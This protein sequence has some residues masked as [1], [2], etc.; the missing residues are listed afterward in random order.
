MWFFESV[1]Y[2]FS[3]YKVCVMGDLN[4]E[5]NASDS[6]FIAFSEFGNKFK[7]VTCDDLVCNVNFTYN[8]ITLGHR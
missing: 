8:H 5:C 3:D 1:C 4:F 7:L 6:G 2:D